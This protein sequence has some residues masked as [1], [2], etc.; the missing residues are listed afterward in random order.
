MNARTYDQADE[1]RRAVYEKIQWFSSHKYGWGGPESYPMRPDAGV[2]MTSLFSH[3]GIID[4]PMGKFVLE[5]V[6][7]NK[8]GALLAVLAPR[9]PVKRRKVWI[10][11]ISEDHVVIIKRFPGMETMIETPITNARSW[12]KIDLIDV[13][14]RALLWALE[15]KPNEKAR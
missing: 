14:Y 4:I 13:L 3:Q 10:R 7:L 2:M 1:V 15:D 5:D 6:R 12:I 11:A 8:A 9:D